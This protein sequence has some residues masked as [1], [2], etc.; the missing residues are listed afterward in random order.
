MNPLD[1]SEGFQITSSFSL[2]G[3][4]LA[5]RPKACTGADA[6]EVAIEDAKSRQIHAELAAIQA[7]VTTLTPRER[8]ALTHVVAGRLNKQIAGDLGTVEKTIRV[9]RSRM[10]EKLGV[11]TVADLVRMTE[12]AGI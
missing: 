6:V 8:E 5:Q 1:R 11:C 7:K 3:L 9:H 12:K 2:P 4:F 10:M